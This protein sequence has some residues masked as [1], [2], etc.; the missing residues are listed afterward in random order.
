MI[1]IN[2]LWEGLNTYDISISKILRY[3]LAQF[4]K[5]NNK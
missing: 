1:F 3:Q 5:G 2:D 4:N